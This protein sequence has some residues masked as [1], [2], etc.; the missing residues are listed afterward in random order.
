ME[1]GRLERFK[2][3]LTRNVVL[4]GAVSFLTDI[5]S[6]MLYPI[7][8]LFLTGVLH[9][10]M[11]AV[12]LIEGVAEAT[13]SLLKAA[14]GWWSDRTPRR[15]PFT[16][17]GYG[18]S[19]LSKPVLA[20]AASWH[21]V[22][23]SRFL[24]RVGKG[25]RGAAR[26]ALIADSTDSRFWGKAFGL[27][28]AM[29]TLGAA[30]GPLVALFLLEVRHLSYQQVFV[31]AFAPAALG[32]LVL[33]GLVS[34]T[35]RPLPPRPS[36]PQGVSPAA[37]S[38]GLKR[39]LLVYG[40]FAAGNSSDVFILLKAKQAG[41]TTVAVILAYVGYN[42]VYALAAAPAGWLSD[43][44]GRGRT[45]ACGLALFAGVY[46]GFGLAKTG[47]ALWTLFGIYGLYAA[48][49]EGVAKAMV[50]DLSCPA[51]RGTA[52]GAFH[53]SCGLMAFAA[54]GAAGLLWSKVSP[55]APFLLAA[56]C[57]CVSAVLML[58]LFG[59]SGAARSS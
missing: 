8:P 44:M 20:L 1:T 13:A 31:L 46:L 6:E 42:I 54:S 51:N 53:G 29:D 25:V 12:G 52:M 49:T 19:A 47:A 57:G 45:L 30:I 28:R 23:L 43:R 58:A 27:H 24:D 41:F 2:E 55:A 50:A 40:V 22:L 21:V 33:A 5:S 32:V 38:P 48:L 36:A 26:D 56:V 34:E 59:R 35:P 10:P 37:L 16:V 17:W 15:K 4:L 18:L 3:G 9:A 39:F 11:T 14:S 7:L